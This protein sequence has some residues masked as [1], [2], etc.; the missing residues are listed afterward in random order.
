MSTD[1]PRTDKAEHDCDSI[2]VYVVDAD[3]A[4]TLE[5]ELTAAKAEIARL[6]E[7]LDRLTCVSVDAQ[8][9]AERAEAEL[10]ERTQW[11]CACGGTDCAGMKENEQLRAEVERLKREL[12]APINESALRERN[13][14]ALPVGNGCEIAIRGASA[15]RDQLR[16]RVAE[17]EK[18]K[19]RLDWLERHIFSFEDR[20]AFGRGSGFWQVGAQFDALAEPLPTLRENIDAAKGQP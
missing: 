2:E 6:N 20:D 11:Q 13:D 5:R 7:N 8:A 9:R 18:D 1:T 10:R 3:F 16:A 17:L 12:S 14:G 19:V 15:E 4:R